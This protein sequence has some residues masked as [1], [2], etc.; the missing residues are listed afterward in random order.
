MK[1]HNKTT[2]MTWYLGIVG[3]GIDP[4]TKKWQCNP[5]C[6]QPKEGILKGKNPNQ[7]LSIK[8]TSKRKVTS[9]GR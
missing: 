7:N 6:V 4:Q 8:E 5:I 9:S 1:G 3:C 2:E